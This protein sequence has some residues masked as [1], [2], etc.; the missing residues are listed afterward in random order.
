MGACASVCRERTGTWP[1]RSSATSCTARAG[2]RT[3]GT[4]RRRLSEDFSEVDP[5]DVVLVDALHR[6]Q[7]DREV[8][9]REAGR[10]ERGDLVVRATARRRSREHGT[11]IGDV[12]A[13]ECSCLDGM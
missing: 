13:P 5:R 2:K 9:D 12:L 8:L 7:R 10:V 6:R 4:L 11:E 1:K 3:A